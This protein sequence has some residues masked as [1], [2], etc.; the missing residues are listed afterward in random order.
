ML[1]ICAVLVL[2]FTLVAAHAQERSLLDQ[3]IADDISC[4]LRY[5][6]DPVCHL[7]AKNAITVCMTGSM[8]MTDDIDRA[9]TACK[10]YIERKFLE[11]YAAAGGH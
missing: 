5:G 3:V 11:G 9:R 7:T 2:G 6:N 10:A 1:K 8:L 4:V